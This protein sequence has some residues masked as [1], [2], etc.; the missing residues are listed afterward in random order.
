[1]A[2]A[3]RSTGIPEPAHAP[4]KS[5]DP[6]SGPLATGPTAR[7]PDLA[8]QPGKTLWLAMAAPPVQ[9]GKTPWLAMAAPPVQPAMA[10]ARVSSARRPAVPAAVRSACW[11]AAGRSAA[12]S[13]GAR[14]VHPVSGLADVRAT[15][16]GAAGVPPAAGPRR[17]RSARRTTALQLASPDA[18]LLDTSPS[19][20]SAPPKNT[21]GPSLLRSATLLSRKRSGDRDEP[22]CLAE[23]VFDT[24]GSAPAQCGCQ[25]CRVDG[26]AKLTSTR[27]RSPTAQERFRSVT[28]GRGTATITVRRQRRTEPPTPAGR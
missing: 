4:A 13:T 28:A 27:R 3:G 17:G 5:V 6:A 25:I 2:I 22:P 16:S 26:D 20:S 21:G 19:R 12:E 18:E 7:T 10:A 8:V 15:P 1:M 23:Q 14:R 9:P 11:R 24:R